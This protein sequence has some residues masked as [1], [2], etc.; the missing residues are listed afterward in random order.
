MET[1]RAEEHRPLCQDVGVLEAPETHV[2][3]YVCCGPGRRGDELPLHEHFEE[4]AQAHIADSIQL[5]RAVWVE[6][7]VKL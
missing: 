2:L 1:C 3:E 4:P 7:D 6:G 5:A